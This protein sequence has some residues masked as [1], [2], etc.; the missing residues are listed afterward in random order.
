M[1]QKSFRKHEDDKSNKRLNWKIREGQR[2]GKSEIV[3]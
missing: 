1:R 2:V 3:E